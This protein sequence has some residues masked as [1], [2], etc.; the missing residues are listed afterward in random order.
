MKEGRNRIFNKCVCGP[1]RDK[2]ND[3]FQIRTKKTGGGEEALGWD[4]L[5]G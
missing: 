2:G 1:F 4:F 5:R 3:R